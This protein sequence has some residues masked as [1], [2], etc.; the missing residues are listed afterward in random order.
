MAHHNMTRNDWLRFAAVVLVAVGALYL[1]CPFWPLQEV[2]PLGLDLQ[3]GVRL[4][5]EPEGIEN[6]DAEA[7]TEVIDRITTIFQNRTDAYGMTNTEIRRF[8]GERIL[9]SLPG[10]TDPEEARR[11]IGQTAML[12]FRRVIEAGKDPPDVLSPNATFG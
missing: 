4:V 7:Q 11:P 2:V 12:E 9:V 10:A 6:M 8:G 1:V 3:G 5:L